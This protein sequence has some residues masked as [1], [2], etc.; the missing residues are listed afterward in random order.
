MADKYKMIGSIDKLFVIEENSFDQNFNLEEYGL[1]FI[2]KENKVIVDN[3]KW[4]GLAK[5][6]GF[7]MD[8]LISELKVENLDRPSKNFIYPIVLFIFIV[9]GYLNYKRNPN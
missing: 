1:S 4:N 8:D 3:L 9:F 7:E 5:K 2:K 6:S